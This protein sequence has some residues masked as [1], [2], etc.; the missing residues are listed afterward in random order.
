MKCLFCHKGPAQG[1]SVYRVNAKGQTGVWACQK[2]MK[3]TDATIPP[4]IQ[5]ISDALN[6]KVSP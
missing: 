1:V 3:Q 6:K 2:H 4:E 5:A